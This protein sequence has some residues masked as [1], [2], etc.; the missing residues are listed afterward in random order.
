[1]LQLSAAE[2]RSTDVKGAGKAG[3]VLGLAGL[4]AQPPTG[5][6]IADE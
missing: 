2:F 1:V 3:A 5:P 6:T 4:V